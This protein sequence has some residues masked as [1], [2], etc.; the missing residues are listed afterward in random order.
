MPDETATLSTPRD[1]LD[2]EGGALYFNEEPSPEAALLLD[3][4]SRA[5]SP[6]LRDEALNEAE[7]L[8]PDDLNVIVALYR[9]YYFM[10]A[11]EEALPIADR[12][13]SEAAK[14][15]NLAADWHLLTMSDVEKTGGEAMPMLRF[16]LWALKGRAYL[17]MRLERF[18]DALAP[19]EKLVEL[20]HAN[21][22]NCKPLLE[23]TRERMADLKGAT[24]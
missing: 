20:D 21:R 18:E 15:L 17:L 7:Q 23:L 6:K 9:H 22:L 5:P 19:L 12:A 24:V 13:M 8:A 10:Q 14:R 4:A 3:R 1:L 11:F 2:F 16:Y